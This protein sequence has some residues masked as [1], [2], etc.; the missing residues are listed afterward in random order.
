MKFD[1]NSHLFQNELSAKALELGG[2]NF[3]KRIASKYGIFRKSGKLPSLIF[4]R[5]SGMRAKNKKLN[6]V[7]RISVSNYLKFQFSFYFEFI[8]QLI[9]TPD[10]Y[11][12]QKLYNFIDSRKEGFLPQTN[13]RF[14][15]TTKISEE[16]V[17]SG[18]PH[19]SFA[20]LKVPGFFGQSWRGVDFKR[21]LDYRLH[22]AQSRDI[23]NEGQQRSG[24]SFFNKSATHQSDRISTHEDVSSGSA[25]PIMNVKFP[26]GTNTFQ[27]EIT[28]SNVDYENIPIERGT[29]RNLLFTSSRLITRP[30]NIA[31]IYSNPEIM[32]YVKRMLNIEN[33]GSKHRTIQTQV[34]GPKHSNKQREHFEPALTKTSGQP[35]AKT[36]LRRSITETEISHKN[37]PEEDRNTGRKNTIQIQRGGKILKSTEDQFSEL[38]F[39]QKDIDLKYGTL[40][41]GMKTLMEVSTGD[42]ARNSSTELILKKPAVQKTEISSENRATAEKTSSQNINDTFI[43]ESFKEKPPHEINRIADT[44]YKIIEKRI[45]IEKDRRGLS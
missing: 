31:L 28:V 8:R 5:L 40:N 39:S 24:L 17:R 13:K 22:V 9:K 42:I 45:S 6:P 30:V 36:A 14:I 43:R 4:L 7:H 20:P 12:L 33:T 2:F 19:L 11:H 41:K 38:V 3:S 18:V 21:D 23:M 25:R 37:I 15:K 16:T 26:E 10:N 1:L 35:T 34:P 29:E 32:S 44:V 27:K